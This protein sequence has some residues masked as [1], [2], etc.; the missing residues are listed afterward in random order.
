MSTTTHTPT[1]WYTELDRSIRADDGDGHVALLAGS[2][3]NVA[4]EEANAAFIVRACNAHDALVAALRELIDDA[5]NSGVTA[6][7]KGRGF[8]ESIEKARAAL[9]KAGAA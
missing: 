5:D 7:F 6:H 2:D 1:P 3:F 9:A 8:D 4:T